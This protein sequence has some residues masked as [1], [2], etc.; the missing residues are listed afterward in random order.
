MGQAAVRAYCWCPRRRSDLRRLLGGSLNAGQLLADQ[1]W[2]TTPIALGTTSR[3]EF[4]RR[5][6][7]S[8]LVAL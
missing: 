1:A 7:G 3:K 5:I 4:C 6:W 2:P 8:L